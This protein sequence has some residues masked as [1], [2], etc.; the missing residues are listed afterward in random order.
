MPVW[1]NYLLYQTPL[2]LAIFGLVVLLVALAVRATQSL[3]LRE[4]TARKAG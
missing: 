3:A 4:K 1:A 2:A